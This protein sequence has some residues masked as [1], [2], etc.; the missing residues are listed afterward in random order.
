MNE[1]ELNDH[2]V[3]SPEV[4]E[5]VR[6][7]NDYCLMLEGLTES[8]SSEFIRSSL[9][10]LSGIYSLIIKMEQP[11]SVY[12]D[13][14]EKFVTEQSWSAIFQK[15]AQLLGAQNEYLR[16]VDEDE[17]DKSDLV[18]HTISEDLSDIY[19]ELRDFTELYSRGLEEIMNDALWEVQENFAEHWGVKLLN[20]LSAL[21]QVYVKGLDPDQI[22]GEKGEKGQDPTL[23]DNSMFRKFQDQ[24]GEEE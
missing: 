16:K 23:Y 4:L 15:I 11:E 21:H 5:F 9:G 10:M 7:S 8:S 18:T 22:S 14:N 3:Y 6:L 20:V 12:D 13:G 17:Y 24:I 1:E 19:Q 2:I